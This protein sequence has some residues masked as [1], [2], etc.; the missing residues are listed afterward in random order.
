MILTRNCSFLHKI[1][2]QVAI[3]NFCAYEN[4]LR[5]SVR[6][7]MARSWYGDSVKAA[8]VLSYCELMSFRLTTFLVIF[9]WVKPVTTAWLEVCLNF[10]FNG[11]LVFSSGADCTNAELR[12]PL[13]W[14]IFRTFKKPWKGKIWNLNRAITERKFVFKITKFLCR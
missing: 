6:A 12:Y 11:H 10:Y 13:V 3:V 1:V 8:K 9:E 2:Y 5:S 7:R 14:Q 4:T